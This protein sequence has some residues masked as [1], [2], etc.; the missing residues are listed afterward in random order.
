[1]NNQAIKVIVQQLRDAANEAT[2]FPGNGSRNF[3]MHDGV[4]YGLS[5]EAS[6]SFNEIVG[7]MLKYKDFEQKFSAKYIDRKLKSVFAKLISEVQIDLEY[8]LSLLIDE[9][10]EFKQESV[11]F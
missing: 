9:L 4:T 5:T 6:I 7:K 8:E 2:N 1:M 11:V 3:Q 10:A